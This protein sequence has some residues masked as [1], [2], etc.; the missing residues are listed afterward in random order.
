MNEI[1]R[2]VIT[3]D[4]DFAAI[5]GDLDNAAYEGLKAE[6][7]ADGI[8]DP[9]VIWNPNNNH[10]LVD[11]HNRLKVA[12]ELNMMSV[13]VSYKVFKDKAEAA[14]WIVSHQSAR[15]NMTDWQKYKAAEVYQRIIR[16]QAEKNL[17]KAEGGD[18]K[19]ESFKPNQGLAN[20]PKV[21]KT[22]DT[23][24]E[25]AAASGLSEWKIRQ[26]DFI[27]KNATDEQK[28]ALDSGRKTMKEVYQETV[29]AN[30]PKKDDIVR[31]YEQIEEATRQDGKTV[32]LQTAKAHKQAE[33]FLEKQRASDA[34]DIIYNIIRESR[35]LTDEMIEVYR[36][37]YSE[38]D[39]Q[40]FL[41][42]S[43]SIWDAGQRLIKLGE[44][45]QEVIK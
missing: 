20:S 32:D 28:A 22:I 15:R 4:P 40:K 41:I 2:S 25:T 26:G 34:Y 1:A 16:E 37:V 39:E 17:H 35:K 24:K 7:I 5:W 38:K 23:R 29:K 42:N 36:K 19:S 21:E 13:P 31:K 11:G 43:R 14:A 3:I 12:K 30:A 45:T 10:I 33:D 6:I 8:R 27:Q 9:L 44:W 18:R